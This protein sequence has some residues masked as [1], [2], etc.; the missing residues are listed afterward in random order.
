MA[1]DKPNNKGKFKTPLKYVPSTYKS[2]HV[3][4]RGYGI[5]ALL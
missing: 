4:V 5:S 1:V 3:C 2:M